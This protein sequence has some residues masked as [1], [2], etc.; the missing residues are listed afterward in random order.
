MTSEGRSLKV[1]KL[2]RVPHI[3]C[4]LPH[5]VP[6]GFCAGPCSPHL[7][8]AVVSSVPARH[9][10]AYGQHSGAPRPLQTQHR[11][12]PVEPHLRSKVRSWARRPCC[13]GGQPGFGGSA[14]C[15]SSR[16]PPF[17]VVLLIAPPG[18]A[19]QR[20]WSQCSSLEP[21]TETGRDMDQL[22]T[23]TML[24]DQVPGAEAQKHMSVEGQQ[25]A[26]GHTP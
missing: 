13:G 10:P 21:G 6:Q 20:L 16:S 26:R 3:S 1:N 4:Q 2:V 8:E 5:P 9:P 23:W 12:W 15:G 7:H 22:G 14:G 18:R 24:L 19:S 11:M 17:L 25:R